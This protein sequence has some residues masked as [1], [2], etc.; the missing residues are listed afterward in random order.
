VAA[1]FSAYRTTIS[2]GGF[3]ARQVLLRNPSFFVAVPC[4][5]K[6]RR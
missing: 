4:L 2:D 3:A 6:V 1:A 5:A